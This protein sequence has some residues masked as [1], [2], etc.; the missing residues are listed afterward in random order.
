MSRRI[1]IA[2]F[3]L[4]LAALSI[5]VPMAADAA[6]PP[7]TVLIQGGTVWT[8][9]KA[10][11][12][13]RADL[14]IR[15]GKIAR[16][17]ERID[18]PPGS[19]VVD[20]TGKHVTPGLIDAHSHTAVDGGINEG[21]NNITAEVRIADVL[22][23]TDVAVYRELAGGL[24]TANVLHGSANSI[25]GQNAVIKLRWGSP[26]A[27][28]I[29][30]A[31]PPGV[32]FALGENPK[33]SNFQPDRGESPRYP[34]TRMGVEASIRK[35]FLAARDYKKEWAD[36]SALPEKDRQHR[37]P[38]RKDLQNE[39][40]VEILD[41]KR[42][43]HAH[44][45][46]QDEILML[47]RL[48]E[49]FGFRIA[50]FQHVLEGYKVADEIAAHG[51]GGSTFSDWWAYKQEAWDAIPYN[52]ALMTK[53]GVL[54]SYNSDSN[55]LARR[56][57]LEAAKSIKY[58]GLT[59]EEALALVTIN[60]ARQ[61]HVDRW[62]GSL[63]AGKDADVAIWSGHPLST[64]T[65]CEQTWVDGVRRFDR[66]ADVAARDQREKDRAAL[67]DAVKN[68]DRPKPAAVARE[69]KK[70]EKKV[71]EAKPAAATKA[72]PAAKPLPYR[73]PEGVTSVIALTGA[74]IHPVIGPD[75]PNGTIVI[76]A[77][78][79]AAV[80]S[81]VAIPGG[82][83]IVKLDGLHV[84]PGL[85]DAD[86]VVGLTEVGSVKG[87][88]D[89]SETGSNNA[90]VRT[91]LAV[92]PDSELIPVTRANGV[93]QVLTVPSG[94]LISG[95]SSLTR[96]DGWTWEELSAA[97]PVALHI[98][99]PVWRARSRFDFGPPVSRDDAKKDREKKLKELREAFA[100]ARAYKLAKAAGHLHEADPV[101]E[102]MLPALD[103]SIPVVVHA[104]EIRQIKD[105]LKWSSEEGLRMI[106]A[107]GEDAWRVA[108][109]L[110]AAN[111]P[112]IL[113]P[114]LDVPDRDDEA[115]DVRFTS[116]RALHDAGVAF[117]ISGGGGSFNAANTRNLPYHAAMAAAFGLPR[118]EALKAVTLY[119]ARIL[120]VERDLGS[121]EA[122]KS[123]SLIV[124][125]GDPLEIRTEVKRVYIDGRSVDLMN[126]HLRLY[127]KFSARPRRAAK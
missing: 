29:F 127:Q 63:E 100:A 120:G 106:L 109:D 22:D 85:I 114:L 28:L 14:L 104:G 47:I 39:A 36:Y 96:L 77:G 13:A 79:I 94:G 97:S 75:I 23:G 83:E 110:K 2:L 40:L 62:T 17:A 53:R 45:Y 89:V 7:S 121:I 8:M 125:T 117:C 112:V 32:K 108:A 54:V 74:T 71:D 31:A 15:D 4:A 99:Y 70:E 58:G 118:D 92:F 11:I 87:S 59:E 46:R 119:P 33:R 115:Y 67:I 18:A 41:G 52:G 10:G 73:M 82:A 88:D 1:L 76:K 111:V 61:L 6:K 95:T 80:G 25:G 113:G 68:A 105:A 48:A 43:V 122:G 72:A 84:Y 93:T 98:Q 51:A 35:A 101:L 55:E 37:E 102:A 34:A 56:L 42:L 5:P 50:T 19:L 21:S 81:G 24:T 69:E 38:P 20:A 60:P 103:G 66:A 57:N 86:T 49:E 3:A 123:A 116:A 12:L 90:D 44:C 26:A 91:D 30:Q 16:I 126:K 65:V 27:D 64:Y 9:S 124:T 78:R 107:G